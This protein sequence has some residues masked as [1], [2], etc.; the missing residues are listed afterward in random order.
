MNTRIVRVLGITAAAAVS[1]AA[2]LP[3]QELDIAP[4]GFALTLPNYLMTPI[5]QLG[6]LE[7]GA[8]VARANDSSSNWYNPAG[9]ALATASSVSSSAGSYQLLSVIPEDLTSEDT[10]GSSQQV[11]ALV[12]AV[13]KKLFGDDRW[14]AGFA[15]VRTNSW[16]QQTDA[17]IDQLALP[18][19]RLLSYSSDSQFRR[20][21]FSFGAGFDDDDCWRFGAALSVASTSLRAVGSLGEQ[22]ILPTGLDAGLAD[23]R[24]SGSTTQLRATGG[25]QYQVTPEILLGALVRSPGL[26]IIRNAD[27]SYDAVATV[28]EE[29]ASLSFFD[30]EARFDYKLPLQAVVG[31]AL[32]RD[33]FEI[34]VDVSFWSGNS[35][36]DLFS[37]ERSATF[38]FDNGQGGPPVVTQVPFEDV[39]SENDAIVNFA[40]GGNWAITKNKVWVLH[41]GFGTDF[42][43]VGDADQFFSKVDLFGATLGVSGTVGGLTAAVG[44]NYQF[45]NADNVPLANILDSDISVD[46]IAIIYSLAYRF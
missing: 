26:T 15:A 20:S 34:E 12:G 3:A 7:G 46:S 9:L 27:Y 39:T 5:G 38:I 10:G 19:G 14:T 1:L 16:E 37:S 25:V 29:N 17:R 33:R 43:Q 44:A 23:R 28:G 41:F 22:R 45:G 11:P 8:F 24:V 30:P 13:V 6:G 36:Y 18:A 32:V 40:V 35:P 42:S 4:P 21:E 31:A 2:V